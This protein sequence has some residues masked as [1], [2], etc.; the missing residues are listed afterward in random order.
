MITAKEQLKLHSTA[1]AGSQAREYM[2]RLTLGGSD[3]FPVDVLSANSVT[4]TVDVNVVETIF[5]STKVEEIFESAAIEEIIESTFEEET[6]EATVVEEIIE[7]SFVEVTTTASD[8]A[9][10]YRCP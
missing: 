2:L 1:A 9:E 10:T 3:P 6:L 5:S 8:D 4:E 7:A